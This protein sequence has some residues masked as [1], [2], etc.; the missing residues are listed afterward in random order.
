[1]TPFRVAR[2][3]RTSTMPCEIPG[4]Y[5]AGR[6]SQVTVRQATEE[7]MARVRALQPDRSMVIVRDGR[8]RVVE[9]WTS[10]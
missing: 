7:E 4:D 2:Y 3:G 1:M 8:G 6:A 9:A 5:P 10:K